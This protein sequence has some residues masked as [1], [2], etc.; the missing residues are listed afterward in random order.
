MKPCQYPSPSL[1]V[2]PSSF[3]FSCCG[4]CFAFHSFTSVS[5]TVPPISKFI[6]LSASH[7]VS[8][9]LSLAIWQIMS[10]ACISTFSIGDGVPLWFAVKFPCFTLIQTVFLFIISFAGRLNLVFA[11]SII[12]SKTPHFKSAEPLNVFTSLNFIEV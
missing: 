8:S 6:S 9:C 7:R 10:R 4:V 2:S 1:F 11:F 5:V 12:L 3:L